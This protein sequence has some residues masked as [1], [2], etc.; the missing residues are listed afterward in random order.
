MRM[1][2]VHSPEACSLAGHVCVL[3]LWLRPAA[4]VLQQALKLNTMQNAMSDSLGVARTLS[5]STPS[6]FGNA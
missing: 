6:V 3:F 2:S 4:S 1:L 5:V